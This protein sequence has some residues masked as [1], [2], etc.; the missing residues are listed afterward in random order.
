MN[1][2]ESAAPARRRADAAAWLEKNRG[3]LLAVVTL[4]AATLR[5]WGIRWGAPSRVDLH[6]DEF[7]YVLKYAQLVSFHR[8]DPG[9]LNYPQ[10]LIY[11]TAGTSWVLRRLGLLHEVWQMHVV[12]RS[13]SAFFGAMTAPAVYLLARELGARASGALLAALWAALLPLSVWE[14]HVA[15]TDVMMTFW[16]VVTL[17]ASVRLLRRDRWHDWALAGA[18]LGLATGS[19]YTAALAAVAILLAAALSPVPLRRKALGLATAGACALLFCFLVTPFSF[20]RLSDTLAAMAYERRHTV[21]GH[22]GFSVPAAGIQYHRYVYQ[23]AAAWPF[24]FGL[25]LYVSAIAGTLWATATLDR[26][27]A[28]VI[29][30]ALLFFGVTGSWSLTPIRYYLPVLPAGALFAGL[31]QGEWLTSRAAWKRATAAAAVVLAAGYTLVFTA[32]TARRFSHETRV[33]AARWLE[34]YLKPG[35]RL[36]VAGWGR[37]NALPDPAGG[38]Q[39]EGGSERGL[40]DPAK[41]AAYDLIE[42]SSLVSRRHERHGDAAAVAVYA[43]LKDPQRYRL[44]RRFSAEFLNKCLYT[45]L[46]PMFEGYFVSPT[47]EFYAPIA[48]GGRGAGA[49][50]DPAAASAK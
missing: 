10:F 9:F 1:P 12:G 48:T 46:D 22:Y 31:W 17:L 36:Y 41:M 13:W 4:V 30:F 8:P 16:V 14:S 43:G 37:Y 19:K 15:V 3:W 35:A 44:V 5:F 6:P 42:T 24:S 2:G 49:A 39:V 25:G 32:Q 45:R 28:V 34:G 18:A 20:I 27:K 40:G 23:I 21:G 33:E 7:D 38:I 11:L 47:L 50:G 29:G 26:R